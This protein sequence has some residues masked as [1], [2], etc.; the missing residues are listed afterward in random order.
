MN[1]ACPC[2]ICGE[3]GHQSSACPALRAP[4][5]DGF[6]SGGNGGGGHGGDEED[7]RAAADHAP[8]KNLV[9]KPLLKALLGVPVPVPL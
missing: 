5:K 8:S 3:G 1:A 2:V 4:L 6:W 7:E 9:H